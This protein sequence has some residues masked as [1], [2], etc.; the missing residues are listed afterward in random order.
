MTATSLLLA[1]LLVAFAQADAPQ[2]PKN[3][4]GR[5]KPAQAKP[6]KSKPAGAKAAAPAPPGNLNQRAV[7]M[8]ALKNGER[9]LG[10]FAAPASNGQVTFFVSREWLKSALPKRYEQVAADETARAKAILEKTRERILAWRDRRKDQPNL[11]ALLDEKL[12]GV[13][14]RLADLDDPR[15]EPPQILVLDFSTAEIR[16]HFSQK[17]PN[18]RVL[19]LA[20]E[21]RLPRAEERTVAALRKDLEAEKIDADKREP[22]LS[23]RVGPSEQSDEAWA[24]R[25][26]LVE[27][28]NSGEPHYQGTGGVLVKAGNTDGPPDFAKLLQGMQ[29]GS[30]EAQLADLLGTGEAAANAKADEAAEKAL[31]EAADDGFTGVRLTRLDQDPTHETVRVSVRFAASMPGGKWRDVWRFESVADASQARPKLEK[32]LADDPQ[33]KNAIDAVKGLGIGVDETLLSRALRHGAATQEALETANA[34]FSEFLLAA[35]RRLDGP[36]LAVLDPPDKR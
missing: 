36:P 7:D 28:G 14:R 22:D 32:E 15:A 31:A 3:K 12:A 2:A 18:R 8:L 33:V 34:A 30:L 17:Q 4:A 1:A 19:G 20:W 24:A 11:V 16:R 35:S 21:Q 29:G 25:V 23:D 6:G 13:D 27:F 26:A 9:F 5:A 10:M